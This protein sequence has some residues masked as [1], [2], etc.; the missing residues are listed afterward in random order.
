MKFLCW[1]VIQQMKIYL[2]KKY[3][4]QIPWHVPN[5]QL[6]HITNKAQSDIAIK[7]VKIMVIPVGSIF[8]QILGTYVSGY[9]SFLRNRYV[10]YICVYRMYAVF[11]SSVRVRPCCL[12]LWCDRCLAIIIIKGPS[13]CFFQSIYFF[14]FEYMYLCIFVGTK[15]PLYVVV[16]YSYNIYEGQ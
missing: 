14:P 2:P 1:V 5:M 3:G 9:I 4:L 6:T 16:L 12:E 10:R 7:T 15:W 13:D 11:V 8:S